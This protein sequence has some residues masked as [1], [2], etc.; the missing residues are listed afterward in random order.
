MIIIFP[1]AYTVGDRYRFKNFYIGWS[2]KNFLENYQANI[3]D[4]LPKNEYELQ[5]IEIDDPTIEED[6]Q[7]F[8]SS[9]LLSPGEDEEFEDNIE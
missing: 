5:L 9:I 3:I 7:L 1:G 2:M 4:L 8:K 6:I